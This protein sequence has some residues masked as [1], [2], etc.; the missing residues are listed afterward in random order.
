ML[1]LLVSRLEDEGG[2]FAEVQGITEKYK[3][4]CIAEKILPASFWNKKTAKACEDNTLEVMKKE[5]R[6]LLSPL[7]SLSLSAVDCT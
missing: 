6:V 1:F 4:R 2:L 7:S 3:H 5:V